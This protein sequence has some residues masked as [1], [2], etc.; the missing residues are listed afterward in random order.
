VTTSTRKALA[1]LGTTATADDPTIGQR[2]VD[3]LTRWLQTRTGRRGFLVRAGVVGAAVAADPVGYVLKPG[4]A[5]ASVCG[6]GASC[7][8]GWSVFCATING[9][10]NSCPPGSIAAGWW[11]AD[12]ASLCGGRARYIVD[13]NATC[14]RCTSA[15]ARAG[16]CSSSCW[17]CSCRCGPG[18]SCDQRRTCCNAFRYGQCNTQV[19]QV[20][21]VHCRVVSCTPPWKFA[22]C[23]TSSATD[24]RT[25]DHSSDQLPTSY[26]SIMRHYIAIGENGSLL[27]ATI[28]REFAVPGGRAQSYQ[29]GRISWSSATGARETVGPV[30]TRYAALRSESGVLGFPTSYPVKTADGT[31]RL[32]TFQRGRI[33]YHPATGAHETRGTI[34]TRYSQEGGES[35]RLG[36]PTTGEFRPADGKGRINI[37]QHGRLVADPAG[38]IFVLRDAISDRYARLGGPAGSLGYPTG[39]N[40][41]VTGGTAAPFVQGRISASSATGA[42]EVRGDLAKAYARVGNEG[43]ILGYPLAAQQTAADGRGRVSRF[44]RGRISAKATGTAFSTRGPVADR[45]VQ[46]GAERSSLGYPTADEVIAAGKRTSRFEHGRIVYDETTRVVTVIMG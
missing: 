5:Y 16:I 17:S 12:G 42:F 20:G 13:C 2:A 46:L 24:N 28:H 23:T 15:G 3:G 26:S 21:G 38:R 37:F 10:V 39:N 45:Y 6:S 40:V 29:R 14:T 7:S 25:R 41:A 27:G 34:A 33:S 43:G 35:G 31:G 19:H 18:S 36:Y 8:S 22:N 9:G 30:F 32:Q 1:G 11:K 44:Q 4:T